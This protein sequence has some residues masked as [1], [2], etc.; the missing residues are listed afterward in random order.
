MI[1]REV[2]YNMSDGIFTVTA[3]ITPQINQRELERQAAA[4]S[5]QLNSLL[6]KQIDKVNFA[7]AS[8]SFKP[9]QDEVLKS[10]TVVQRFQNTLGRDVPNAITKVANTGKGAFLKFTDAINVTRRDM[11]GFGGSIADT[12]RN[13]NRFETAIND[14][15]TAGTGLSELPQSIEQIVAQVRSGTSVLDRAALAGNEFAQFLR[16]V[17]ATGAASEKELQGIDKVLLQLSNSIGNLSSK[18]GGLN[19]E[20]GG[21]EISSGL[22]NKP[23]NSALR[24]LQGLGAALPKG[25]IAAKEF[26]GTLQQIQASG[27]L[28][29]LVEGIVAM[30]D[31]TEKLT[32]PFGKFRVLI[33][34]VDDDSRKA[35]I[36]IEQGLNKQLL[37]MGRGDLLGPIEKLTTRLRGVG[38]SAK[39]AGNFAAQFGSDFLKFTKLDAPLLDVLVAFDKIGRSIGA[40][41]GGIG[42][43]ILKSLDTSLAPLAGKVGRALGGV[44]PQIDRALA[45]LANKVGKALGGILP[46]LDKALAPLAGTVGK[47]FGQ[48]QTVL[49]NPFEAAQRG[50]IA[51]QT[52]LLELG[53]T[54]FSRGIIGTLTGINNALNAVGRGVRDTATIIVKELGQTVATAFEPVRQVASQTFG[55]IGRQGVSAFTAVKGAISDIATD[56]RGV[57]FI[58]KSSFSNSEIGQS[59]IKSFAAVRGALN[60]IATDAKG[61]GFLIKSA[62]SGSGGGGGGGGGTGSAASGIAERLAAAKDRAADLI[63]TL[64]IA[65]AINLSSVGQSLTNGLD[66]AAAKVGQLGATIST[67]LGKAITFVSGNTLTNSIGSFFNN[68]QSTIASKF[69]ALRS[70]G[71]QGGIEITRGF[72]LGIESGKTSLVRA[73]TT[74]KDTVLT[75]IQNLFQMHS[76][77]KVMEQKG[78]DVSRGFA[79]GIEKGLGL[80]SAATQKLFSSATSFVRSGVTVLGAALAGLG[81]IALA[82]GVQFNTLQQVIH[83]TLPVLVG[84]SKASDELLASINELNNASPFARSSFLELTQTLAGFGIQAKKIPGLIDAIQQTVAATG[85][86]EG[87]LQ[88][89]GQAFARIQS[90]GRLSLD[91]LQSFSSRGVD[92]I[93][94]LGQQFGKTQSQIRD[95]I[96]NGLVPAGKAVDALTIGLKEKFDGATDAVAKNLPGALDRVKA[97]LRDLGAALTSAFVNPKGGGALVDFLNQVSNAIKH[98]TND[99]VPKFQPLLQVLA[100]AFAEI[101]VKI[102]EFSTKIRASAIPHFVDELSTIAPVLAGLL[103]KLPQALSFIPIVG[104][105]IAHLGGPFTSLLLVLATVAARSDTVRNA[106]SPMIEAFRNLIRVVK[107]I[108]ENIMPS[109]EDLIGRVV[110]AI[111]PFI[112][113]VASEA[114][115][116]IKQLGDVIRELIANLGPVIDAFGRFLEAINPAVIF[117]FLSVILNVSKAFAPLG[118]VI[119]GVLNVLSKLAPIIDV[120]IARFIAMKVANAIFGGIKAAVTGVAE[121]LRLLVEGIPVVES[122]VT[123]LGAA[124]GLAAGALDVLLGPIGLIAGAIALFVL[125]KSHSESAADSIKKLGDTSLTTEGKFKALF[126]TNNI[127]KFNAKLQHAIE[128]QA[129]IKAP[130]GTT[131]PSGPS[132]PVVAQQALQ[133]SLNALKAQETTAAAPSGPTGPDDEALRARAQASRPSAQA[134]DIRARTVALQNDTEALKTWKGALDAAKEAGKQGVAV[135]ALQAIALVNDATQRAQLTQAVYDGVNAQ[136]ESTVVTEKNSDITKKAEENIKAYGVAHTVLKQQALDAS[137][138]IQDGYNE[139]SKAVSDAQ[140]AMSGAIDSLTQGLSTIDQ[141]INPLFSAAEAIKTTSKAVIDSKKGLS[142]AQFKQGRD[143]TEYNKLLREQ[144]EA[145][146]DVIKPADELA[147]AQRGLTRIQNDLRDSQREL[148]DLALQRSKLT[149]EEAADNRASLA[150]AEERAVINLNK[151]KQAQLDLETKLNASHQVSIDL[152]GLSLDQIRTQLNATRATLAARTRARVQT[153]QETKDEITSARLDVEDAAQGVKDAKKASSQFEID[154][155]KQIRDIDEKVLSIGADI[156]DKKLEETD[157]NNKINHLRAGETQL[158]ATTLDF[159]TRIVDAKR[160]QVEDTLSIENANKA[161]TKAMQDSTIAG[162]QL[163]LQSATIRQDTPAI[164]AAQKA[165]WQEKQTGL[166]FNAPTQTAIDAEKDKVGALLTDYQNINNE[167]KEKLRLQGLFATLQGA[168][169]AL[170]KFENLDTTVANE[171]SSGAPENAVFLRNVQNLDA[172]RADAIKQIR[173][174]LAAGAAE[175]KQTKLPALLSEARINLIIDRIEKSTLPLRDAI[176]EAINSQ[177][178]SLPGFAAARG[179][180]PGM[181]HSGMHDGMGLVRMFEFGKEAVLPLTRP[182][183]MARIVQDR[184]VLPEVLKALPGFA[185]GFTPSDDI[186]NKA[187]LSPGSTLRQIFQVIFRN[188]GI[189][190]PGFAAGYTPS[191]LANSSLPSTKEFSLS[192]FIPNP[193]ILPTILN[194]MPR[195][196]RPSTSVISEDIGANLGTVAQ[197]TQR[198]RGFANSDIYRKKDQREFASTIGDSVKVAVKEALEESG[199]LGGNDVDINV[200]PSTN[201]ETL[202]AREVQR[203]LK[204]ALGGDF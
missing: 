155:Q 172:V 97:K 137:A 140:T 40:R 36:D 183:D 83:A 96:S 44:L 32:G 7:P 189:Q 202:I 181:I 204:K 5:T 120:L 168:G 71:E 43:N 23:F 88:E 57:G 203:Q 158:A 186:I 197:V 77:S 69:A 108:I 193:S 56:A 37:S 87:D 63:R 26:G 51:F 79:Q 30:K 107:P 115:P 68:I 130:P 47:K 150:R 112:T 114:V 176:A 21:L 156:A 9:F 52:R 89:L 124:A 146:N 135:Q 14:I 58:L 164:A 19:K 116:F 131:G 157:S 179:L 159:D 34:N 2:E 122:V 184:R 194:A 182:M 66:Q 177:H 200:M 153:S 136:A 132:G 81:G 61:I 125:F 29:D 175:D 4:L 190:F 187:L 84:S 160:Q 134:D 42:Q 6:S 31:R 67:N 64:S 163:Q 169:N 151:A 92:V 174:A 162:L 48:I 147:Q 142:D 59:A 55:F 133:G 38:A 118:A 148:V 144:A 98:L 143:T 41:T 78:E 1:Q 54:P 145:L 185:A 104:E 103:G 119:V 74:I 199:K 70:S 65:G 173:D 25:S 127:D 166:T 3:D 192:N 16:P 171:I 91:I 167:L 99:I 85:G 10:Q 35:A 53:N 49:S 105:R 141:K 129:Q 191:D 93:S 128:L 195:W 149:G 72:G 123:S 152:T 198:D 86:N 100:H 15:K 8:G 24:N 90:Q 12:I 139:A 73:A 165:I 170:T 39:A 110:K 22:L 138:A 101:G 196:S 33:G 178:L 80:V 94:I 154:N 20:F 180:S 126:N 27:S 17:A 62:F 161:I 28:D 113:K 76:P 95:M 18:F 121:G 11:V 75:R 188:L 111:A 106:L 60:E 46:G 50:V 13:T 109:L 102:E 201:N 117:N 45:P 82:T